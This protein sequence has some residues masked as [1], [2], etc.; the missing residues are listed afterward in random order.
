[1]TG[2]TGPFEQVRLLYEQAVFY[3]DHGALAS[4]DQILDAAEAALALARGRIIHARF[5]AGGNDDP[6]EL[7]LFERATALY[8]EL[9]DTRGEGE[10]RFWVGTYHQVVRDDN[11]AALPQLRRARELAAAASDP[12][13]LSYAVRH[14]GFADMVAGRLDSA[15]EQLEESIRLRRD[16]GFMPGVA[17]GLLALAEVAAQAGDPNQAQALLDEAAS[18]ATTAGAHG[19]LLWIN[20]AREET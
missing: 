18:V 9:G 5:L 2:E 8:H 17:A 4:A 14:L 7:T 3:G 6:A 13:T 10:A 11:D 20:Q 12:L 16:I 15:R 1:M 19:V